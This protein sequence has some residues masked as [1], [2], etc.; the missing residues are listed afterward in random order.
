MSEDFDKNLIHL[1]TFLYKKVYALNCTKY[2][3]GQNLGLA[4]NKSH[5]YNKY[6]ANLVEIYL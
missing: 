3:S 4:T 1:Y 6:L 2:F 5:K